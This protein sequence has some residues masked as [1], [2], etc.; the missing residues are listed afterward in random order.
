MKGCPQKCPDESLTGNVHLS[1][2]TVVDSK[3]FIP[4]SAF[5]IGQVLIKKC[6]YKTL[7]QLL[8]L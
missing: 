3:S 5:Q 2:E 8:N 4:K 7:F 6:G 1:M